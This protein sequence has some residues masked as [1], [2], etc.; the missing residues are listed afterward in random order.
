[1]EKN[2]FIKKATAFTIIILFIVASFIPSISG[3][4]TELDKKLSIKS[5]KQV[6]DQEDVLVTCYN[7]GMPGES[8]KEIE[9]SLYEAEYLY[10]K[11]KELNFAVAA[12][13]LSERTLQL[14]IEIIDL[15]DE[16]DL[17]P[18]GLSKNRVKEQYLHAYK[19]RTKRTGF[20]PQTQSKA[21]EFLCTFV[22]SGSGG[23]L[24]IIA[25]P[26][27]IPILMIPIPRLLMIWRAQDAVTSCG[28]LRSGTGFIAY[29]QQNGIAL[30][31]WGLGFTFS[32]PPLMGVYGLAGYSLYASVNAEY[33]EFYPPNSPP[34][35]S[36]IDPGD[37]EINVPLS[38][39]EIR[40]QIS[41]YDG[42]LMRYTV[43][44][45][46]DIGSGSGNL[47]PDG[48]Y[49]VP[50]NGLEDLTEYSWHIEVTDGMDTTI[51][52]F[53][54]TAEAI[55][56]IVSN[57][58]PQDD[59]RYVPL[60]LSH[61]SFHLKDFQGDPM[62]Y[63]VETVPDIG[64]GS[65]NGVGDGTYSVPV[66]GL[67]YS[68]ECTWYVNATD[69]EHQTNKIFNFQIEHEM[70]F[71]PFDKGWQYRKEITIDHTKI[72]GDLEN[73]PILIST[74]DSDLRDKAQDD[75]DDIL[76]MDGTGISNRLY[77]EIE[78]YESSS[79]KLV[80]WANIE[81]L[82]SVDDTVIFMYYG[83]PNSNN[84]QAPELVWDSNYMG[85]WHMN[86][87][88]NS[89]QPDSTNN[90]HDLSYLGSPSST[91]GKIGYAVDF[92][93]S[94][95]YFIH[96]DHGDFLMG[97][98]RFTF[99]AWVKSDEDAEENDHRVILY[100]GEDGPSHTKW[101]SFWNV[102]K[103]TG[104]CELAIDDNTDPVAAYGTTDLSDEEWHYIVG[105]R[106]QDELKI[107]VDGIEEGS[108]YIGNYG[109]LDGT[110]KLYVGRGGID[111]RYLKGVLDELVIIKGVAKS[112]S[113]VMTV[114]NNQN[115]PSSFL[116]FGT[117]E[118]AP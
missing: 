105:I 5:Q 86:G 118:P 64:S 10:E 21:S 53:T 111:V 60:S 57:P 48:V 35:I 112:D 101:Y 59:E 13:P 44:T 30:G 58:S 78:H 83:N 97:S 85:V 67:D 40:F 96:P 19:Q 12:D 16:Y 84:Q 100:K 15:A 24:P 14:Q 32:L 95:G 27:F 110:G 4:V 38:L 3:N 11:I 89:D 109:S 47:K 43:T 98:G 92:D 8:S 104:Y 107:W 61:L 50:I 99:T 1:M 117:E 23:V 80:A 70:T 73:F 102:R 18:T 37:G 52:D 77:H 115:D 103:T 69:G 63:T 79:G 26:R 87:G 36:Q 9:I 51:D 25:L 2:L 54:F 42:D 72:N 91:D 31:F 17:L 49:S 90:N 41:D 34:V 71:D 7:F 94:T 55:A 46:P 114:Y 106:N 66:S 20:L 56:P 62:D 93:G 22:S 116:S 113:W 28:G 82:S 108:T 74:I 6:N 81:N 76:F 75:G 29:G 88:S 45:T 65:G 68:L 33:I 39:S